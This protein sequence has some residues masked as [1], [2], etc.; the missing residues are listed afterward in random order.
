M[1]ALGSDS[2]GHR[3]NL[4]KNIIGAGM[5]SL[6]VVWAPQQTP[7]KPNTPEPRHL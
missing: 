4:A 7:P 5:L 1:L 6:P 3:L 2:R